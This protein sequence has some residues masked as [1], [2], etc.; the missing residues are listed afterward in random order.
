MDGI[1]SMCGA[2]S[3]RLTAIGADPHAN[4]NLCP[5]CVRKNEEEDLGVPLPDLLDDARA[6]SEPAEAKPEHAELARLYDQA[7]PV[8]QGLLL[9]LARELARA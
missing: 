1:C 5:A 4:F 3:N 9:A 6:L 2:R 8:R 7:S